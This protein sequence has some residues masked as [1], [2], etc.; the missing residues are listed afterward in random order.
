VFEAWGEGAENPRRA[1]YIRVSQ[2]QMCKVRGMLTDGDVHLGVLFSKIEH[3]LLA[4]FLLG[5]VREVAF[6]G[7]LLGHRDPVCVAR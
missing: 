3:G 6:E 1:D 4:E 7:L 2:R 5:N